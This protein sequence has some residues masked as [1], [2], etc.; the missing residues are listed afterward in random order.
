[1]NVNLRQIGVRSIPIYITE[2][3][4]DITFTV[5]RERNYI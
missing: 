1:M 2:F 4:A 5:E 3:S